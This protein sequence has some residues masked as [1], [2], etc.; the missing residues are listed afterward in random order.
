ML[1]PTLNS[2]EEGFSFSCYGVEM[3]RVIWFPIAFV[4]VA[5]TLFAQSVVQRDNGMFAGVY[6]NLNPNTEESCILQP[7]GPCTLAGL[8]VYIG[9]GAGQVQLVIAG[10]PSEG[11]VPP[12]NWVW[13]YNTYGAVTINHGGTAQ[14]YNVDISSLGIKSDGYDRFVIQHKAVPSGPRIGIDNQT[15]SAPANS[16]LMDPN[17][18]NGLGLPGVIYTTGGHFLVRLVVNYDTPSGTGSAPPPAATLVDATAAAG[19]VGQS[20][21]E[22]MSARVSVADW[23]N[24]GWDDVVVGPLFFQNNKNG[25]FTDKTSAFGIISNGCTWGDIDNDGD[26]DAYV[27]G[28]SGDAVYRNNGNG[29]FTNITSATNIANPYPTVTP[30]WFDYNHDGNLDL[31]IANGRKTV[32]GNEVFYQDK[33]WR[34]NGN[35]TFTDVTQAAGIAAAEPSPFEDCWGAAPCDFNQ[36]GWVDIFVAT[37][38]LAPD[39]LYRNNGNGTFTEVA[40]SQGVQGVATADSRYFGHGIGVDFAD[41][42]NDGYQDMAVGNLGHPDWRGQVSNPSLIFM[43]DGPMNYIFREEHQEKR[44]KF[45][46]MNAGVLFLDANL[47]GN[48]DL[49]HCQ[50]SYT[51]EGQNGEPKRLSRMYMNDGP[52]NYKFRDRTWHLGSLI[53]GAWTAVRLD[54]DRDGDMD[55]IAA[56]PTEK[57]KLF[58][59]DVAKVGGY[60]AIRLKGSPANSIPMDAYGS[61]VRVYL[62]GGKKFV[63]KLSGGGSGT[64][65]SQN[66]NEL[67]FGLGATP[68]ITKV[69]VLFPDFVLKTYTGL[70]PN[71]NYTLHYDGTVTPV[72]FLT[73]EGT[74]H[75]NTVRLTWSTANETNNSGFEV[76]KSTDGVDFRRIG[77]VAGAGNSSSA[78][79]YNF[80]DVMDGKS[81]YRLKQIDFDGTFAFSQQLSF[82][83]IEITSTGIVSNFPNPFN[84]STRIEYTVQE[85]GE[86]VLEV[87]DAYGRRVRTL[88]AE[89]HGQGKYFR[90]WDGTDEAGYPVASGIYLC[91]LSAPGS[92]TTIRML[93]QR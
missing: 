90:S 26:L 31:F 82:S 30:I 9:G 87:F 4:L 42:N 38:R 85:P 58:K 19:I 10:D 21:P 2:A 36:D 17:I 70:L 86:A 62:Q 92:T 22:L 41:I 71:N 75:E 80:H 20:T 74:V 29:T 1:A 84:P 93:L 44:V 35:G 57:V 25:T 16:F 77:F 60:L 13:N 51:P 53:H 63:Q 14:W 54:F 18:N 33:L 88:A 55:I 3:K 15:Q 56:S 67:I 40:V 12:T 65:A 27:I 46:E 39:R 5:C 59:N 89:W 76:Q 81:W 79:E 7:A 69:E 64:T 73:F 28:T 68:T 48:M 32:G 66:S 83:P 6:T 52:P 61:E 8:Q 43:N 49:F 78:N 47:D 34:N 11:F 37:Y 91:R 72:E 24:D 45:F 23:N 50:Y